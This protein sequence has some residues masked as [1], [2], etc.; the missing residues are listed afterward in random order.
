MNTW[1][2]LSTVLLK[3]DS[4]TKEFPFVINT[5]EYRNQSCSLG[6]LQIIIFI[7]EEICRQ[8]AQSCKDIFWF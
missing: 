2:V 1:V 4:V 8:W 6:C 7:A 3:Y 5:L